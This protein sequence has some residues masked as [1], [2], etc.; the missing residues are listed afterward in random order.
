MSI[1]Y[2]IQ[3]HYGQHG[4]ECVCT[5][6]TMAEARARLKE[7]DENEPGIRHRIKSVKA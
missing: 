6:E 3:G 5:E 7:Y 4:W 1:E 2:E